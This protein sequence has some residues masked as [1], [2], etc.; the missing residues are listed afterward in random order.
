[1]IAAEN[2]QPAFSAGEDLERKARCRSRILNRREKCY[3]ACP[4]II[5]EHNEI[6]FMPKDKK[7]TNN[8]NSG[9][10]KVFEFITEVFGWLQ[11][12]VSQLLI[13]VG[14]GAIIYFPDPSI[15]RLIIGIIVGCIGLAI[16]VYWATK[17]WKGKGTIFFLSQISATPELDKRDEESSK[18]KPMPN[19]EKK[20]NG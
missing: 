9:I 4:Q 14:I 17:K 5:I 1:M 6:F 12:V 15:T 7:D 8:N 3:A 18:A 20:D 2:P 13:G 16:G 10:F 11:I 19:E